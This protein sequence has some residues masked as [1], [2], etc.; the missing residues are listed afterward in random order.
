MDPLPLLIRPSLYVTTGNT[1]AFYDSVVG[2][3]SR[4]LTFNPESG[5]IYQE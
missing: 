2:L 5:N 3:L 4:L 1:I